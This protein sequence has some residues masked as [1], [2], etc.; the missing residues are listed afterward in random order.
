MSPIL[1]KLGQAA[2]AV[3][4][5]FSAEKGEGD[6]ASLPTPEP[7]YDGISI[8]APGV[9]SPEGALH[10]QSLALKLFWRSVDIREVRWIVVAVL[11][12][13]CLMMAIST[14]ATSLSGF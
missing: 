14:A 6:K 9:N 3:R 2:G 13:I 11:R 1:E 12:Y 10:P 7:S 4:A 8:L 5:A